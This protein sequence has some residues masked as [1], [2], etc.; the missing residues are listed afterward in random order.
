MSDKPLMVA[1]WLMICPAQS[2]IRL[3]LVFSDAWVYMINSAALLRRNR[4]CD[5]QEFAHDSEHYAPVPLDRARN[6]VAH[7]GGSLPTATP[8]V[9]FICV[10]LPYLHSSGKF[11]GLKSRM[12]KCLR[13]R[14]LPS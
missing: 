11:E 2:L 10:F 3:Q 4:V 5:I 8:F 6:I 7:Q 14:K 9:Y 12:P 1:V 13:V